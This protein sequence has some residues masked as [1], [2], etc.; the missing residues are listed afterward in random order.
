M[1]RDHR[2]ELGYRV[3]EK[4][5]G[6]AK[7]SVKMNMPETRS[8]AIILSERRSPRRN[9]PSKSIT[10]IQFFQGVSEFDSSLRC[11]VI[12]PTSAMSA[13]EVSLEDV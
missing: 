11:Q 8:V 13:F 4:I 6:F 9:L 1:L 7:K 3:V 5:V 10:Q 2:T 12:V